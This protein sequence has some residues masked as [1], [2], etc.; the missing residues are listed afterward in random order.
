MAC[1]VPGD[2][3]GVFLRSI[4]LNQLSGKDFLPDSLPDEELA[5]L[6]SHVPKNEAL[7]SLPRNQDPEEPDEAEAEADAEP[8]LETWLEPL[9]WLEPCP[10]LWLELEPWLER[11]LRSARV[12]RSR[13]RAHV[14]VGYARRPEGRPSEDDEDEESPR[15]EDEPEDD[16]AEKGG[17]GGDG[18]RSS[19]CR[20]RGNGRGCGR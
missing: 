1:K 7:E 19:I 3:L 4:V 2:T 13:L 20:G 18:G 6:R 8:E 10:E 15:G 14:P 11:E 17:V 9:L 5:R 16:V 12:L